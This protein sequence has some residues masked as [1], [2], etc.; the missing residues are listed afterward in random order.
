V[1]DLQTLL[2]EDGNSVLNASKRKFKLPTV[3]LKKFGGDIKDWLFWG[4]FKK[5]DKDPEIDDAGKVDM[6]LHQLKWA[7]V[8]LV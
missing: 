2:E 8:R 7:F 1:A 3:E 4:Q 5:T 6:A